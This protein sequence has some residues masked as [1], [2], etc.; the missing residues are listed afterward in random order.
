MEPAALWASSLRAHSNDG[1]DGGDGRWLR[2]PEQCAIVVSCQRA[3][4]LPVGSRRRA[5]TVCRAAPAITDS[6]HTR[7]HTRGS[8]LTPEGAAC[9]ELQGGL[10]TSLPL[11]NLADRWAACSLVSRLP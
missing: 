4:T 7:P 1:G 2:L 6:R 3:H 8:Q 11:A 10:P 9:A 5:R